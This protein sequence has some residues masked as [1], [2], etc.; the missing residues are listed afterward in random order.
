MTNGGTLP[1]DDRP[2]TAARAKRAARARAVAA[3]DAL[4]H[5]DRARLSAR[6]CARAAALPELVS[7]STVM[8][9][10]SFR[11]EVDTGPLIGACLARGSAVALPRIAGPRLLEAHLVSDPSSDL[12]PGTWAIPEP[13]PDLPA[14]D[15]ARIDAIV[16]PGAAFSARGA[17]CG[18]GGG[19]Y[20]A[21]LARLA[22]GTP[23]IGLAFEVQV[24]DEVPC[25]THDLAVDAVVTEERVIRTR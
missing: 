24:L 13:R 23:R 21:F 4:A 14:V 2:A 25:E 9:F 20:D 22:D 15:P 7:A 8:L 17:R 3:R 16:V 18:Y 12:V 11:S 1:G 10:A 19:F 6:I 5:A